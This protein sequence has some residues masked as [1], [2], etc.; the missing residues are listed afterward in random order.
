LINA[1]FYLMAGCLSLPAGTLADRFEHF[2][3]AALALG[4]SNA[5]AFT[6]LGALIAE[7]VTARGRGAATGGYNTCIYLGLADHVH[8]TAGRLAVK[9]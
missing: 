2:I 9:S 5:L 1:G 6:A 4:V 7:T 3:A 8:L